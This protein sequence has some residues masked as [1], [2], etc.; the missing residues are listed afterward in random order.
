MPATRLQGRRALHPPVFRTRERAFK[1]Y[2]KALAWEKA[3]IDRLL[4]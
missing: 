4:K 2:E 1:Q 3:N